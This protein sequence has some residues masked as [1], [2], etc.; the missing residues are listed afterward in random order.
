MGLL[1]VRHAG[2]N[3]HSALVTEIAALPLRD[4]SSSGGWSSLVQLPAGQ[5][6]PAAVQELNGIDDALLAAEGVP[7]L[8]A[9]RRFLGLLRQELEGAQPGAYLLLIGHNIRGGDARATMWGGWLL[10]WAPAG[11]WCRPRWLSPAVLASGL[12]LM[13]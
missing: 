9:Y 1:L 4:G 5:Q 10:C 13:S 7:F 2:R 11:M 3:V 6:V 12:L 8:D